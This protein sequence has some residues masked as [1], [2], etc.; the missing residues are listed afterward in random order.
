[1]DVRRLGN[2]LEYLGL[3]LMT[4]I[5]MEYN[6]FGVSNGRRVADATTL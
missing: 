5:Q 4:Q 3:C 6:F 1:M 2:V